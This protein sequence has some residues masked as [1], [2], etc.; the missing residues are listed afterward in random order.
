M[1]TPLPIVVAR[2]GKWFVA[3]CP[4][5]KLAT[6]GKTEKEARENMEDLIRECHNYPDT[7]ETSL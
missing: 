6:Q 5:L 7:N 2:E 3:S 1:K 4:S